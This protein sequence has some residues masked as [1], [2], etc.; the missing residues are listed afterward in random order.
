MDDLFQALSTSIEKYMYI[1]KLTPRKQKALRDVYSKYLYDMQ[2][3]DQLLE[4]K[5]DNDEAK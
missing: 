2:T 1:D 4:D 3:V 5:E